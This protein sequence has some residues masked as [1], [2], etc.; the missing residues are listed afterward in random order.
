M[1]ER[2]A[3]TIG[4]QYYAMFRGA[5]GTDAETLTTLS[6]T[7]R[8]LYAELGLDAAFP[9]DPKR[10]KVAVNDEFGD[11]DQALGNGDLVVFIA[12]VA[13]G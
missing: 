11:W 10:L 9:L 5:R 3:K 7:P 13:G 4:M 2:S 1:A 6:A 8:E 12:P